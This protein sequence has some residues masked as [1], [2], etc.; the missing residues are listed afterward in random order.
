MSKEN[1][2]VEEDGTLRIGDFG[3][4]MMLG[5][6]LWAT[7]ATHATGTVRW[8][9]PELLD[10]SSP[11]VTKESDVYAFGMTALVSYLFD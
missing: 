7:T 5:D 1:V 2:F 11:T 6:S 9:A 4:S 8:M 3:L 10:G